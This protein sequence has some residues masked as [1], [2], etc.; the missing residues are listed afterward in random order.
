MKQRAKESKPVK[1]HLLQLWDQMKALPE[2]EGLNKPPKKATK[3]ELEGG[4]S[5]GEALQARE[6][7]PY[8]HRHKM[9]SS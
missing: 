3:R 2:K 1:H 6:A 9:L 8:K 5:T 7:E 4:S